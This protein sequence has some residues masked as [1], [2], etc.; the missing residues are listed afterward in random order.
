[1]DFIKKHYEKILL[2]IVLLGLAAVATMFPV[3]FNAAANLLDR[4]FVEPLDQ[5]AMPPMDIEGD[6]NLNITVK[7]DLGEHHVVNPVEWSRKGTRGYPYRSADRLG[8]GAAV[9]RNIVPQTLIID[10]VGLRPGS[11]ARPKY[12]M[13][14]GIQ[15]EGRPKVRKQTLELNQRGKSFTIR[16][17]EG[18]PANPTAVVLEMEDSK[19]T[20]TVRKGEPYKEI[21]G[22]KADLFYPPTQRELKGVEEKDQIT[23]GNERYEVIVVSANEVIVSKPADRHITKERVSIYW[24]KK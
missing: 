22:Y 13:S 3:K 12:V 5:P 1:M 14:V 20:L 11:S 21:I 23:L 4:E 17:V 7:V 16:G 24:N 10:F 18:P 6:T 19:I 15:D 8:A 9:V 2:S